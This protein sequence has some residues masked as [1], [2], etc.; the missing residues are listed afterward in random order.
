M[1]KFG[2]KLKNVRKQLNIQQ[3]E[4]GERLSTSYVTV[5]Q[6]ESGRRIPKGRTARKIAA[7][8]GI[9]VSELLN[10]YPCVT[11]V[12][13]AYEDAI[14]ELDEMIG[15]YEL[16]DVSEAPGARSYT[17]EIEATE[18]CKELLENTV[19]TIVT[20]AILNPT[21]DDM[22][23]VIQKKENVAYKKMLN[24]ILQKMLFE[25][26]STDIPNKQ[27]QSIERIFPSVFSALYK[28]MVCAIQA[29]NTNKSADESD[30]ITLYRQLNPAG[31]QMLRHRLYELLEVPKYTCP[32][33]ET[34]E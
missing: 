25:I 32:A 3:Q 22:T 21:D 31:K 7:A 13:N 33:E 29:E 9:N 23:L 28:I 17:Y 6:W 11:P 16:A 15:R 18:A 1:Y 24:G 8:L 2:D 34:E 20:Q 12:L 27:Y 10:Y 30:I 4:L 26:K 5:S 19:N 14:A